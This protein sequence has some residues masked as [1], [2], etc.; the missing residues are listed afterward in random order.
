[1]FVE[2]LIQSLIESWAHPIHSV[3]YNIFNWCMPSVVFRKK[4]S[5]VDDI[6]NCV[7]VLERP[8]IICF[9]ISHTQYQ[10]TRPSRSLQSI[11]RLI[12][13]CIP[14]Q[15]VSKHESKRIA[16]TTLLTKGFIDKI[17][18]YFADCHFVRIDS[19][20][21]S[22]PSIK[23]DV[24]PSISILFARRMVNR[25]ERVFPKRT[26]DILDYYTFTQSKALS[27]IAFPSGV[28]FPQAPN[29]EHVPLV[30]SPIM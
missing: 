22:K 27:C 29:I 8:K 4:V 19:R 9:T 13:S 3:I 24:Q 14:L 28:A 7:T 1:M 21:D 20:D 15:N 11:Y 23:T 18:T 6:K 5:I 26:I 25:D 2:K 12:E 30:N 16:K 10:I 17:Y